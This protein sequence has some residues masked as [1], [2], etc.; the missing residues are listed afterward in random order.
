[1]FQILSRFNS[2]VS[3]VGG[4]IIAGLA[5]IGVLGAN[6]V[7]INDETE[8]AIVTNSGEYVKTTGPGMHWKIPF[9]QSY[10]QYPVKIKSLEL[11]GVSTST[12]DNYAINATIVVLYRLP[13][14]ELESIHRNV[15]DYQA[16]MEVIATSRF[17]NELGNIKMDQLAD[18]RSEIEKKVYQSVKEEISRLFEINVVDF[19]IPYYGW[20]ESFKQAAKREAKA[21]T[22]L[23][24]A[25][26]E[27][28]QAKVEAE[29]QKIE[30]KAQAEAKI[31]A[32]RGEA[33]SKR[34]AADAEA[35]SI[36]V[37]GEAEAEALQAKS[38]ALS[39]NPQLVELEK[40]KKW[41]GKL[42]ANMY[43]QAPIP[44]LQSG[45]N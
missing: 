5:I 34:L 23:E 15:P 35:H 24:V 32:A 18:Q 42:P 12:I 39:E 40:A 22:D 8:R 19:T 6:S 36:R 13:E 16:K 29:R 28:K 7:Y 10:R 14:E 43:G 26:Q 17:K 27:T 1:M 3:L 4:G 21:E 45:N 44:F 38:Q 2:S 30:A 31:E 11:Q 37:R 41:D 33:E 20:S 9:Q 25:R